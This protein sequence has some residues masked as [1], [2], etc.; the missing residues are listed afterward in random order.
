MMLQPASRVVLL[1][2]TYNVS[3]RVLVLDSTCRRAA[4]KVL[5]CELNHVSFVILHAIDRCRNG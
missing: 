4:L 5:N 3:M 2:S 1:D